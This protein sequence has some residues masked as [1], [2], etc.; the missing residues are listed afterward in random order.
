MTDLITNSD[1]DKVP[2]K[3]N[4]RWYEMKYPE[5]AEPV[6]TEDMGNLI[7]ISGILVRGKGLN[8]IVLSPSAAEDWHPDIK[9]IT[10]EIRI[11]RGEGDIV[12][13]RVVVQVMRPTLEE[14]SEIIRQTD[15]PLVFIRDASSMTKAVHRK[16]RMAISGSVQQKMIVRDGYRC[17]YCGAKMGESLLTID[18]FVPLELGGVNDETN[19]LT[20]CSKCNKRKGDQEPRSYCEKHGIDYFGLVGYLNGGTDIY[21]IEHLKGKLS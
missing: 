11:G 5:D 4:K 6:F 14:W 15:D 19:Y 7:G 10:N 1:G 13:S 8:A 18:H 20:A 3:K 16:M 2:A 12:H 21:Q 17:M 9:T